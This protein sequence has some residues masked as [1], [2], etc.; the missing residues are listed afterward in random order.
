[1]QGA[2]RPADA[3]SAFG[4]AMVSAARHGLPEPAPDPRVAAA[5]ALGWQIAVLFRPH[6]RRTAST[7]SEE[8]LPSLARLDEADVVQLGLSQVKVALGKLYQP[9]ADSGLSLPDVDAVRTAVA[10]AEDQEARSTAIR[11]LHVELVAALSAVDFRLG[12]AYGLGRAL[13]D[14]CRNPTNMR[15]LRAE[16][17]PPR[18][19]AMVAWTDDLA[20]AFPPHAGH[21]VCASLSRWGA[22]VASASDD[23]GVPETW[24]LL[25]RQGDLWRALLSGEKLGTDMLEIDNYL[26]AAGRLFKRMRGIV[27]RFLVRFPLSALAVLALFVGGIVLILAEQNS[28]ATAAGLGTIFASLGISWKAIGGSVGRL[29]GTLEHPLWGAEIDMAITDAITLLPGAP[30]DA[31]GDRRGVALEMHD[32]AAPAAPEPQ[33]SGPDSV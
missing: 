18:T 28:A 3:V 20:S 5:F 33:A 22:W 21:S 24:R 27:A 30:G 32:A 6:R 10:N 2:G 25:R 7:A 26:D 19:A 31:T 9:V 17:S 1:V 8:D 15:V 16:F 29:L 11:T 13:A 14:T 23:A 4:E 12:K